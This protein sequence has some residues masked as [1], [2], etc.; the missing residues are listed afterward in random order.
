MA[1]NPTVYDV[2]ELAGVSIA[3]VSRVLRRPDD[4]RASTREVVMDAVRELG[5][6]PSGNARGLAARK[7]GVLGLFLPGFDAVEELDDADFTA[8]HRVDF[9]SPG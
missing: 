4:V 8:P 2:A 5:Y 9:L 1:K 6:V 7:T 3:T